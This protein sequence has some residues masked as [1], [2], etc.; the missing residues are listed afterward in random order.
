MTADRDRAVPQT[1]PVRIPQTREDVAQLGSF[2][3]T[4]VER[5]IG[6]VIA[7]GCIALGAQGFV[8][9]LDASAELPGWHPALEFVV[10]IPLVLMLSACFAGRGQRVFSGL[11]VVAYAV[12]MILWPIAAAGLP[13]SPSAEPWMFYLINVGTAAAVIAFPLP[14]QIGVTIGIPLLWGVVRFAQAGWDGSFTVSVV[15]D[16][17]F[18]LLFGGIVLTLG[19]MFRTAAVRVDRARANAVTSYAAAAAV[20]A[21]EQERIDVGALMH[22]SVLAALIAVDRA[23]SPRERTLAVSM[24]R[25]A[26]TRLANAERDAGMGPEAPVG[27]AR[28]AESIEAGATELGHP[29][30]VDH[31]HP[32]E[33]RVPGVVARAL[34]LAAAQAIANAIQHA[35]AAG[36]RVTLTGRDDPTQVTVRVRDHGPGFDPRTVAPDRLGISASIVARM[37]AVGGRAPI[38]SGDDGTEITLEWA[39]GSM[40]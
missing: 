16:V 36:L 4:R 14:G 35:D 33:L 11:F 31:A 25:E 18:A 9:A 15:L 38:A 24:A 23:D 29:L 39:E 30:Q 22:D 6:I 7:V 1:A 10:F 27:C 28:I 3:R 8:A 37:A 5:I 34:S 19:A 32:R 21:T 17:S 26:L 13:A 2:T 12:G 40:A 20:A